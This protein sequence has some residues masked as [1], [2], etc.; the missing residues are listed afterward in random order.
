MDENCILDA[1]RSHYIYEGKQ[2][3]PA[4]IISMVKM[5][6]LNY[7]KVPIL[8]YIHLTDEQDPVKFMTLIQIPYSYENFL[9]L[10]NENPDFLELDS[11][12]SYEVIGT[13]EYMY[14]TYIILN[15]ECNFE[16]KESEV[17]NG[18]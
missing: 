10:M 16:R 8:C 5:L 6:N 2:L 9:E 12:K 3:T 18:I 15:T 7:N 14:P 11:M 17:S 13:S 1:L 4:E